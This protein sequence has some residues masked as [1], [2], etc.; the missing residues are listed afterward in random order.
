MLTLPLEP[1]DDRADPIFRDEAGCRRW[2]AQLQLTNLQQAHDK[3]LSQI[4][5]LNR[6]PMRAQERLNTLELLRETIE[7]LQAELAKKIADKPLPLNES[8]FKV[9]QCIV[10]LWAALTTGYQRCLQS[11]ISGEFYGDAALLCQRCL[12]YTGLQILEYRRTGYEFD[13]RL[14]RQLHELYAHAEQQDCHQTE[15]ADRVAGNSSSCTASYCK[16]L[17]ACFANPAQMTRWQFLQMDRWLALWRNAT[18]LDDSC[19]KSKNDAQPL[20]VDLSGATGLQQADALP[21]HRAMRYLAMVPISKLLRVK[22]VLL[23]Q[24]QTPQQVGLGDHLNSGSCLE[25]LTFLHHI[26]CD[27]GHQRSVARR[28]STLATE[29]CYKPD[30]IFAHMTGAPFKNGGLNDLAVKQIQTLGYAQAGRDLAEMGYPL[31]KWQINNESIMGAGLTRAE[32][33]DTRVRC[34]QLIS[35]HPENSPFFMLGAIVWARVAQP[36]KLQMGIRYLHGRPVAVRIHVPSINPSVSSIYAPAFL[37]PELASIKTPASLIVPRDW[38]E[39]RRIIEIAYP[40]GETLTVKMDFSVERGLDY[41][42]VGFT[43]IED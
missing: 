15:V 25:L 31:E 23:Q 41:E 8:E 18:T 24:G 22:T 7:H 21:H 36:G 2:L 4:N 3:L 33:G 43:R 12:H 42:R 38:F 17:L 14:W 9:L 11:Q 34:R 40:N 30:G 13:S 5:E 39:A 29:L 27:G 37:L 19:S 20:A 1:T 10:Q 26:W 6:C 35:H 28:P 16:T 32:G